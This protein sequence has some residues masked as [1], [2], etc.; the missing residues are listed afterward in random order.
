VQGVY[1]GFFG[2]QS[3]T[4]IVDGTDFWQTYGGQQDAR[5]QYWVT[6]GTVSVTAGVV[7]GQAFNSGAAASVVLNGTGSEAELDISVSA[8]DST[9]FVLAQRVAL[10]DGAL[11]VGRLYALVTTQVPFH[12]AHERVTLELSPAGTLHGYTE[13]GCEV[14]GQVSPLPTQYSR[15]EWSYPAAGC[16]GQTF[17]GIVF[18]VDALGHRALVKSGTEAL[19]IFIF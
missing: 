12:S 11:K 7:N 10:P 3:T 8:R 2:S 13:K 14:R 19:S 16:G 15:I 18:R 6:F 5:S 1:A 17:T 9:N 4:I